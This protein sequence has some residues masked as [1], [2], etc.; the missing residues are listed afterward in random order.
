MQIP[1]NQGKDHK[2]IF[3]QRNEGPI[4]VSQ[5]AI[6]DAF[7]IVKEESSAAYLV[8]P[9]T[10]WKNDPQ[11]HA[12]V[13]FI[14]HLTQENVEETKLFSPYLLAS[15]RELRLLLYKYA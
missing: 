3:I 8:C 13:S 4:N 14:G 5:D 12:K 2:L 7:L 10:T 6:L 15:G 1:V 11:R 9:S